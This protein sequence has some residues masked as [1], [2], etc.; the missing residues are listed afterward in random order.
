MSAGLSLNK[1][2]LV[3]GERFLSVSV[4]CDD[5]RDYLNFAPAGTRIERDNLTYEVLIPR[6]L[7]LFSRHRIQATFFCI[8]ERLIE[9]ARAAAIMRQALAAGHVIGNHSFSH[10]DMAQCDETRR[11]A[12]VIDGHRAIEQVLGVKPVG[13]R[14]PAYHM[15]EASFTAIT[16]LG[17]RYDSSACSARLFSVALRLLGLVRRDYRQKPAAPLQRLFRN[18]DPVVVTGT[19]R[20]IEWPIPVALGLAF[21]GTFHAVSP[22]AVFHAHSRAVASRQHLHYELHPIEV[23]D[24][25]EAAAYDWLPTAPSVNGGRDLPGWL[26]ERLRR[27]TAS[28]RLTTLEELSAALLPLR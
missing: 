22:R 15:S 2:D 19:A 7:E 27:L 8:G 14:G 1:L 5:V 16:D 6:L 17:Y 26:D 28:R 24:R 23:L 9:D 4:D 3:E 10:P 20:V 25:G 18:D 13:Y 11:R 21:Y 12:E